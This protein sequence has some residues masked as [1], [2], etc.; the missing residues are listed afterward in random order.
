MKSSSA[1]T[2]FAGSE[3][4]QPWRRCAF[5]LLFFFCLA[6]FSIDSAPVSSG[7]TALRL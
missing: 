3:E 2:I 1:E 5:V 7:S 4:A 6:P